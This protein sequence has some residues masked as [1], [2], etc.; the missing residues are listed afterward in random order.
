M[1][2]R[3]ILASSSLFYADRPRMSG[4]V[5]DPFAASAHYPSTS[6]DHDDISMTH[7]SEEEETGEEEL[8][9]DA[10][11]AHPSESYDDDDDDDCHHCLHQ[12]HQLHH[13]YSDQIPQHYHH[14]SHALPHHAQVAFFDDLDGYISDD[15]DMSDDAGVPLVNYLE[16]AQLLNSDPSIGSSGEFEF[17]SDEPDNAQPIQD[18]SSSETGDVQSPLLPATGFANMLSHLQPSLQPPFL[19]PSAVS[20]QLEQLVADT[21]DPAAAAWFEGTHPVALTNPNPNALGPGNYSLSDF[22]HHWARQ[23]RGL[24]G[25]PRERGRYPWPSRIND[26]SSRPL[27]HVQYADLIGDQCDFQG[28]DWEHIGVTRREARE[29]R[30]LTYNNYVNHQGSDRWAVSVAP[31]LPHPCPEAYY[32]P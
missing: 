4:S 11:N 18:S 9:V 17:D 32:V 19:N 23:S 26:V 2:P 24:T 1:L 22:L 21:G 7:L 27:T 16:V 13:H 31:W 29:R 8:E 12:H 14:T 5:S 28:V 15:L 20:T 6:Q 3:D 25:L 10:G 30:L